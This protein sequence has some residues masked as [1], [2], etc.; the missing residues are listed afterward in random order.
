MNVLKI[1]PE[2]CKT[3]N[4]SST[5]S[6]S[7][8]S[9]PKAGWRSWLRVHPAAELFPRMDGNELAALAADIKEKENGQREPC[10]YI[11]DDI[12]PILV[13][14]I[15][16]LDARELAGLKIELTDHAVFQQ[17]SATINI[18]AYVISANIHHRH[19]DADTKRKI[20]AIL[21]KAD[22]TKS[23]RAIAKEA[24]THHHAVAKVRQDEEGRGNISH[25]EKRTDAKGRQQPAK[26]PKATK[27]KPAI[28]PRPD[29]PLKLHTQTLID[30]W[31]HATLEEQIEFVKAR[32]VDILR[33]QQKLGSAETQLWTPEQPDDG[34]GGMP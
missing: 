31:D 10:R 6:S 22:P 12:G 19:L 11:R 21:L 23:D 13:D 15:G 24:K 14:G 7:T 1:E 20:I 27:P 8:S 2:N 25:V 34:L 17:L 26:K 29:L 3:N 4:S 16:R 32:R 9:K 28:A 5:S 30:R 18:D 33:V